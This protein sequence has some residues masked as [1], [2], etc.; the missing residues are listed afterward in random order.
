[1]TARL[2]AGCRAF[3]VPA[4]GAL[5]RKESIMSKPSHRAYLVEALPEGSDRKPR[6][7]EVGV[8][9]PHK[10]GQGFDLVIPAGMAISG[11]IVCVPPKDEAAP[12][13]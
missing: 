1:M 11:R 10:Q 7:I 5:N 3:R 12:Q 13:E 2:S 8:I 4:V 9:W 6:W